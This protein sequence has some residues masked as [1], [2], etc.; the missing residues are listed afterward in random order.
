M[1]EK[2]TMV[3]NLQEIAGCFSGMGAS[4]IFNTGYRVKYLS[5]S[6]RVMPA[7]QDDSKILFTVPVGNPVFTTGNFVD[8][9][10]QDLPGSFSQMSQ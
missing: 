8:A 10:I 6:N 1:S 9:D 5:Q 4:M 3:A 2:Q 7:P